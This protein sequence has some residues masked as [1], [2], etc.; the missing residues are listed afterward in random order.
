MP[1]DIDHERMRWRTMNVRQL[2]TRL[3]KITDSQKMQNFIRLAEEYG[4]TSLVRDARERADMLRD[5]WITRETGKW[6]ASVTIDKLWTRLYR[7]INDPA[8]LADFFET[9]KRCASKTGKK[10]YVLLAESANKKMVRLGI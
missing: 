4:Y 2:E 6:I 9:A 3:T 7:I 1:N 5:Q 8:K 10:D